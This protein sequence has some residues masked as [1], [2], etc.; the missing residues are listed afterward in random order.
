MKLIK[1]ILR[2]IVK[3]SIYIYCKIVYRMK[4]E[5]TEN[6]PK[7]EP[8]I[9]CG[10]HRNY[11]DPPLI[12]ITAKRYVRFIAKEELRKNKFFAF[13]GFVFNAIY[14]KRD[15]KDVS[16]LKTVLKS[17]KSGECIALFPEGTRNGL[18]KGEKVKDGAAF[19]AVKSGA[20]VIPVGI[21]GGTKAW[22]KVI[23]RYGKPL[24][25][26]NYT[27]NDLE[28]VTQIIMDNIIELAK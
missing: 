15:S 11:L 27:K 18:E 1:K 19:F 22:E 7:N 16:A 20:K 5:G 24:D 17:L 14:V 2:V 13:L 21:K 12:V 25:F 4:I 28:E 23:I 26:S 3:G 6:I 9:Y 8:L 10:N